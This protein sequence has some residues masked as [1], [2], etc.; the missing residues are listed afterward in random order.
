MANDK[1]TLTNIDKSDLVNYPNARIKDNTGVGD[2][3]PVNRQVY[4]DLHEF[5]AKLMRLAAISYNGL[6]DS[7]GN[8]YQLVQAAQ[9]LA[10]K[11]D[12]L[13]TLN[14][15]GTTVSITTK[16]GILQ[17]G[18]L[19]LCKSAFNYG[20]EASIAGSDVS[21][22]L[23]VSSNFKANDLI[24]LQYNGT[25]IVLT[26]MATADNL[27]VLVGEL[28][29]LKAASNAESIAGS[30]VTKAVTPASL[31]AA[32][33]KWVNDVTGAAPYLATDATPG[34]MSAADKAKLDSLS[35]TRNVGWFSG[36]DPGGG[37]VGSLA[38]V[39][40]NIASAEIINV[41]PATTPPYGGST[42]YL[43]TLSNP[44]DDSNYF[45]RTMIES[46]G[47]LVDDNNMWCPI[48]KPISN[49]TF[50]WSLQEGK[51]GVQNLKIHI[52]AVQLS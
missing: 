45:V 18:E 19:L 6:P 5:F 1:A 52:E 4:S 37:T 16:L 51:G 40:G 50:Q 20:T 36:V 46:Q 29:Y 24:L 7:E 9:A 38:P 12:L 23:S 41:E 42:S 49:T 10:G 2:G 11:N 34:I 8:G 30:I 15:D 35:A 22:T 3:T 21:K 33:Q 17:N 43:I 47:S 44:M 31:K 13:Y 14:S 39:S 27:N 25:A 48:F 26:R 28:L 32:F